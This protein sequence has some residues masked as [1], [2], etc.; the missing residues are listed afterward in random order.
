MSAP[1]LRSAASAEPDPAGAP[2]LSPEQSRFM[3]GL[4]RDARAALA[5][6]LAAPLLA[7][8]L[9]V[10]QA[11]LLA[12]LLGAAIAEGRP[13][14]AL[15]APL[16][17][18]AGLIGL[19]A[20]LAGVGE[21]AGAAAAERIKRSLRDALF[22]RFA[23]RPVDWVRGRTA[24][25]LAS[26]MIEQVDA[27]EGYFARYLPAAIAAVFLPLA[28]AAAVV[29]VEPIVALLFLVTAPLVPLFMALVGYGAERASRRHL[30]A[31]AR[32][33]GL[34]ADRLR[35]LTTLKLFGRAEA[36][37][38][39][40]RDASDAL[41]A[42]T[43]AVLKIAFLSSAVL[44][45]FAALAVAA[46]A[47][48]VGLSYLGL[49]SLRTNPLTLATGLFC[50]LMAP[51]VFLP[52]RQFAAHYHDR[53]AA[54]AATAALDGMFEGLPAAP[55]E[56]P[57]RA[58][59]R[60]KGP[61]TLVVEGLVLDA[62]D[63]R[64]V[65]DGVGFAASTGGLTVILG[66]SGAG[67]ST[68]LEAVRGL[69][70]LDAG[71]VLI[72]DT[73]LDG[74][75]PVAL[76]ERI[77]WLGQRPRIVHGTIADNIRLGRPEASA[78]AVIEAARLACVSEFADLLPHGLSTFVGER[79]HGLSGGEAQRVALARVFLR[80]PGLLLLDE[81]TAHLDAETE[82]R[83]LAGI[84]RFGRGRTI[85]I[86]THSARLAMRADQRLRLVDGRI[87]PAT[88]LR[89]TLRLVHDARRSGGR[90]GSPE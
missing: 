82:L 64:R 23:A 63:G 68:L 17:A 38:A 50:L 77:G 54:K 11:H 80:D 72:D 39:T 61:A 13:R 15:V 86:A 21:F 36:E 88:Q 47:L 32:L 76:A 59:L 62:P 79:G 28:F 49:V 69:R 40:V 75:S 8:I 73:R 29:P 25:G 71:R 31:F 42:R 56:T 44:E 66:A 85:V 81:P 16:V 70:A 89:P 78:A 24:G 20:V 35:G 26:A 45:F 41:R 22:R 65:L 33:S 4:A 52:L 34:F 84:L 9:L 5:V 43:L 53:A 14:A 51:E 12:G 10:V 60:D 74:I 87:E 18:V 48:Y 30:D 19:R 2:R 27:L 46:V 7:G 37:V 83:V 6:A 55:A 57:R 58:Q 3:R 1:S 67:K 90:P